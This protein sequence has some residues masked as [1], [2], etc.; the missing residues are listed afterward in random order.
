MIGVQNT[1]TIKDIKFKDKD[2]KEDEVVKLIDNYDMNM[3]NY[4]GRLYEALN[5]EKM[6]FAKIKNAV[7]ALQQF[8][9]KQE[10]NYLNN[11]LHP[12]KCKAVKVPSP[13]PVP[14]CSFQL[15]NCVTLTTNASGNL[16]AVF[17]PFFLSSTNALT[18]KTFGAETTDEFT[19]TPS[20]LSTLWYNADETL[21]GSDSNDHWIPVNIGQVIPP[22]YDQ[23]RLVSASIVVKYIG[24][25]DIASGV[26]GGA[27]IFDEN[28]VIGS[29]YVIQDASS[30]T[31]S[32]NPGVSK[33]GNFDL[34]M[35]SFYH[36]ENLCLEGL[37]MLY[38]PV[39]NSYEEYTRT[40]DG[41]HVNL[42]RTPEST[43]LIFSADQDYYKSGFNWMI[44][45]LGAPASS[46]CFKV[47]IYC[48]YECLPN[49]SFLNYLPLTMSP[50]GV[51]S[52]EKRR[53]NMIVQ[54]KPVMKLSETDKDNSIDAMPSIWAKMKKKFAGA[55]PGIGKLLSK[56]I[57]K[58]I[59]GL[60][61]GL[62]LAGAILD[63]SQETKPMEEDIE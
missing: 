62:A 2:N 22:V 40:I 47:D 43:Q 61:P 41:T 32:I 55:L 15:H 7:D 28:P 8:N 9:V 30:T 5:G 46:T 12:E 13:I 56:G 21:N 4:L 31:F 45:V 36:Q 25:L 24:R 14:S 27:I 38:F 54:K 58:L 57:V 44:Y 16:A 39:D 10:Y 20:Y 33:Y 26:I 23:Y 18:Q 42:S 52:D 11:L 53:A 50:V 34:A 48:N 51:S 29:G 17:N 60:K 63:S 19:F 37:R 35:D 3:L 59:P 49:A 6:D 1:N